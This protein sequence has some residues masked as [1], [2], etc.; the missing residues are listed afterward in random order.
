MNENTRNTDIDTIMINSI[1]FTKTK[2]LPENSD[3]LFY[4]VVCRN[5]ASSAVATIEVE[6]VASTESAGVV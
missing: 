1:V 5:Y 2:R 3:S 4:D 6:S